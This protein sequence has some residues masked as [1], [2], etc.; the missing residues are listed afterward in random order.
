M[1]GAISSR[2]GA[3]GAGWRRGDL[4]GTTVTGHRAAFRQRPDTDPG[5]ETE[6]AGAPRTSSSAKRERSTSA[7]AGGRVVTTIVTSTPPV[8][9]DARNWR[10][11]CSPASIRPVQTPLV[12]FDSGSPPI[13]MTATRSASRSVAQR[14]LAYR[15]LHRPAAVCGGVRSHHDLG[16][17]GSAPRAHRSLLSSPRR[18]RIRRRAA[19]DLRLSRSRAAAEESGIEG[20]D[21]R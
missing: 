10:S 3:S 11:R 21:L 19:R 8:P 6:P 5:T 20:E 9:T 14:R 15:E 17:V 4:D 12:E 13:D 16:R 7:S 2:S 18:C 1:S